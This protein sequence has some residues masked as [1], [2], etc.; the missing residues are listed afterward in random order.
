VYNESSEI[1]VAYNAKQKDADSKWRQRLVIVNK[2]EVNISEVN[3]IFER[4]FSLAYDL[5]SVLHLESLFD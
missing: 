4:N 5:F 2:V 3:Y 1:V